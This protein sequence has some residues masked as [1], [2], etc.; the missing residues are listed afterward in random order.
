[1]VAKEEVYDLIPEL[2]SLTYG[3]IVDKV[4]GL[5]F[6]HEGNPW[7]IS[8]N[9]GVGD[10]TGETAVLEQREV[11]SLNDEDW[12]TRHMGRVSLFYHAKIIWHFMAWLRSEASLKPSSAFSKET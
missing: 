7:I 6:D 4:E 8:D 1:M 2:K 10:S 12:E 11:L 9:D 5:T 3:Y